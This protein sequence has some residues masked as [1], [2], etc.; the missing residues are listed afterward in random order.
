MIT[1][2][3][4]RD[5]LDAAMDAV[6]RLLEDHPSARRDSL[7]EGEPEDFGL[8]AE[9]PHRLSK[10]SYSI[11][12]ENVIRLEAGLQPKA[13]EDFGPDLPNGVEI[14][15]RTPDYHRDGDPYLVRK[16]G[17]FRPTLTAYL[18]GFESDCLADPRFFIE[19]AMADLLPP[20]AF[21]RRISS[22]SG[23][24][25]YLIDREEARRVGADRRVIPRLDAAIRKLSL[26]DYF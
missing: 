13:T 9:D 21:L 4:T 1:I 15:V 8:E 26:E 24:E 11:A 22:G 3:I 19:P 12:V 6:E 5:D 16:D 25:A 10:R 2:E 18:R 14:R 20:K 17:H 23:R 7:I